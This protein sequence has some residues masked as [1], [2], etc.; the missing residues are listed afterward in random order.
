V[1]PRSELTRRAKA[2]LMRSNKRGRRVAGIYS[3]TSSAREVGREDREPGEISLGSLHIENEPLTLNIAELAHF[4][5]EGPEIG[6]ARN[7]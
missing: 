4:H 5:A 6:L 7:I 3:I 1:V 2:G